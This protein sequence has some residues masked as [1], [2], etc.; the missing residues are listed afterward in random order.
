MFNWRDY[1]HNGA[2]P[3]FQT[4]RDGRLLYAPYYESCLDEY[5]LDRSDISSGG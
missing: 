5:D 3:F 1:D 4:H 2:K